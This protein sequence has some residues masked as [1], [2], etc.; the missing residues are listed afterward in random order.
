MSKESKELD[1]VIQK[2]AKGKIDN[3]KLNSIIDK[4]EKENNNFILKN[5]E[6]LT[7]IAPNKK[8]RVEK[9]IDDKDED[10]IPLNEIEIDL[11]EYSIVNK[12]KNCLIKLFSCLL[13][14]KDDLKKIKNHYNSTIL[15]TFKIYRFLVLMSFFCLL[16]FLYECINHII[17]NKDNLKEICKYH[18]PCFLQYSSFH[19]SESK[20]YS[21]TY[22]CWLIFFSICS[23]AYYYVLS[24]EQKEQDIYYDIGDK[25]RG[26]AYLITSWNFN[27]RN[28]ENSTKCKEA[29]HDELKTYVKN[30]IDKLDGNE[31]KSNF[32]FCTFLLHIIYI[33]FLIVYFVLFFI[34]FL[35][36]DLFRNKK[37]VSKSLKAVDIIA[38]LIAFLLIIVLFR[39][40][41]KLTGIFSSFEAWRFEKYKYTSNVVKKMITAFIGIFSLLFIYIYFTLYTNN[42]KDKFSLFGST[43]ASFFGCPGIYDD[44]RHTYHSFKKTIL[45]KNY[46]N[47][48]SSSYSKCRE[49]ET[50]INF[51]IIFLLYFLSTFIIDLFKNCFNC[52]C[53]MK[54]TF[55]P[56]DS[57]II[58]FTNIILF[59]LTLFYIPYLS[60]LFPLV[61]ILI[62]K[63]QFYILNH[64]GSYSFKE[65]GLS[66]RNNTKYLLIIFIIFIIELIC[67]QGYFYLLSFPHYYKINCYVPNEDI[68]GNSIL[69]Y[70]Y[71]KNWCGPVRSYIRLS[72]IFTQ[73]V[74]EI[75]Y[76][77]RIIYIVQEMP[78]IIVL[79]ALIFIAIIYKNNN[80]D[81]EYNEFM[82]KK[83]RELD[84]TFRIYYDQVSKRDSLASMLLKIVKYNN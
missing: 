79:L 23:I 41:N 43:S 68:E 40:F 44:H 10:E 19:T 3:K 48:N 60:I 74:S 49:E 42:L 26:H 17:K 30:F 72:D 78:F 24:S 18:I 81:N 75:P 5:K 16:I 4:I 64:K 9:D 59:S 57:M 28:E 50:G 67:I 82:I 11:E 46:Q 14:F 76:F 27:Y 22:G 66:K 15:I 80:P 33:I 1:E 55:D 65:N 70:D 6:I 53:R 61:T 8:K 47:A 83:N 84:K 77:G 25:F 12:T 52:I 58:V 39:L 71:D 56:I 7:G 20:V 69:L 73:A 29:I 32:C 21:I 63:F 35:I 62:Y 36:R 37:T 45:E 2:S 31:K 13:P 54:S 38:D 51:L 34:I